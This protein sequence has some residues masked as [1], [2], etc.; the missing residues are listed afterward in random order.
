[1]AIDATTAKPRIAMT[2]SQASTM[3]TS[4]IAMESQSTPGKLALRAGK[5][6]GRMIDP[7]AG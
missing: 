4:S 5:Q 7:G 6:S 1:M 3:V 2:A